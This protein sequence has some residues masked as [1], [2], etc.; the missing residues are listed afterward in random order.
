MCERR[1][2]AARCGKLVVIAAGAAGFMVATAVPLI[3][4]QQ[5]VARW[6]VLTSIYVFEG[7]GRAV[8]EGVR[9]VVSLKV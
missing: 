7:L 1:L 8:F 9:L 6:P 4:T 5:E 3:L 2:L